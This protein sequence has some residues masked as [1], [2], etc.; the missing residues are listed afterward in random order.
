MFTA[1]EAV[2]AAAAG[3]RR[4][5]RAPV[6][7]GRRRR[8]LPRRARHPHLRG[9]QGLARGARRARDGPARA[10]SAPASSTI[11]LR[12]RVI[13]VGD[14]VIA[15]RRPDRDRRQHR[16][17]HAR[18]RAARRARRADERFER[19]LGWADEIRRLGVRA[20]AD[21]P[22][23]ARKALELG[24]EGIGLCRTEHMFMAADR[25]PKMRAMIM[26]AHRGRAPRRAGRAAA[27]AA[28]R[29][30]RACSR[31]CPGCR[32]RSACSTRR[33]TSSCPNRVGARAARRSG[34]ATSARRELA[35][36]EQELERVQRARRGQPDARHPR[37][38]ARHRAPRD[39]RD[40][41]RGDH[42][43][44]RARRDAAAAARRS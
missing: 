5:P 19:V 33:C 6:H 7:R 40:A 41:G 26:A 24:A 22:A 11:D 25:Q 1:E 15:R 27:A 29:T 44:G 20:N 42:A 10:W 31:R 39:L 4:D 28:G 13:R 21:T 36:L 34:R 17:G 16:H 9:R 23:D 37:L 2:A 32:S 18:R 30:S 3:P 38:P 12:A 43:R 14:V 8:R 35:A